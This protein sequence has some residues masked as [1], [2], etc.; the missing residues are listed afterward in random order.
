MSPGGSLTF[1]QVSRF[2]CS[3]VSERIIWHR[4]LEKLA[5]DDHCNGFLPNISTM[6]TPEVVEEV[7]RRTRLEQHW[8]S[9]S[10]IISSARIFSFKDRPS[11]YLMTPGGRYF[12][13][14]FEDHSVRYWDLDDVSAPAKFLIPASNHNR[15]TWVIKSLESNQDATPNRMDFVLQT[16]VL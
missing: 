11:R 1:L 13:V 14:V 12:L 5:I 16:I 6:S 10:P 9:T 4:R 3:L 2:W 7:L 8:T 15:S